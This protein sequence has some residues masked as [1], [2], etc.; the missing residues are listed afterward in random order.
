[1]MHALWKLRFP[2]VLQ[3]QILVIALRCLEDH[4]HGKYSNADLTQIFVQFSAFYAYSNIL[5]FVS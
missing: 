2:S 1:M 4:L 3:L 5:C